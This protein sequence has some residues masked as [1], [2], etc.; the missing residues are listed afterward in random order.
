MSIGALSV[1]RPVLTSYPG[2][3]RQGAPLRRLF[4]GASVPAGAY[5]LIRIIS[6]QSIRK[7]DGGHRFTLRSD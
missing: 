6:P 2:A 1:E 4:R 3:L 7:I 5:E